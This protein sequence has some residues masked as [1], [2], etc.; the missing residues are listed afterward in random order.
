[1]LKQE[2]QAFILRQL[3]VHNKVLTTDLCTSLAVSEDTVR[4]DLLELADIG[5]LVK[6]HGGALSPSFHYS[7]QQVPVYHEQEKLSIAQKGISLIHDGMLVLLS[8]GTTIMQ[9]VKNLPPDLNATFLTISIPVALELMNHPRCEVLFVGNRLNKNTRTAVGSEVVE[10]LKGVSA[11]LCFLGTNSIDVDA[12][13]TDSEWEIVDVKR[14]LMKASKKVVSLAI[15]EKL[16]TVQ[17]FKICS[18]DEVDSLA[19]ELNRDHPSLSRFEQ[20]GIALL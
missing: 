8:G 18:L 2:R 14:A 17:R 3:N 19:T 4:R 15:S 12:G 1:M 6:V 7:V 20:T 13:I 11:D 9:L 10:K 5:Q 16:Y